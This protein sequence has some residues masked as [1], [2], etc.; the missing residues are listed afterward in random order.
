[1]TVFKRMVETQ[2]VKCEM[3]SARDRA[4]RP[5]Q[6]TFSFHGAGDFVAKYGSINVVQKYIP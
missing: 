2:S 5:G 1:M 6:P 4:Q 3:D